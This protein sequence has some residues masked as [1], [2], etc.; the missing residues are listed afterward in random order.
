GVG[1]RQPDRSTVPVG[2]PLPDTT[3]HLLDEERRPVAP[4][5]RGEVW[6]GGGGVARGYAGRPELTGERFVPDPFGPPGGRLYR[7]GDLGRQGPG[8]ALELLGRADHQVKIRGHR[9]EPGEIE[10]WLAE[11]E[12][13][14]EAVVLP[15]PDGGQLRL[16]AYVRPRRGFVC[17]EARLREHAALRLPRPMLPAAYVTVDTWPRT[18]NGKI[19]R[20]ALP[21][22]V[23]PAP[24]PTA[25]GTHGPDGPDEPDGGGD[26]APAN[27]TVR[28]LAG[29][30]QDVLGTAAPP[31]PEAGFFALGGTS[32]D[33][34]RVVK[35][36]RV[37]FGVR[38][39]AVRMMRAESLAGQAAL[40]RAAVTAATG[41]PAPGPGREPV[42]G[43]GPAPEPGSVSEPDSASE[44]G[45]APELG[46]ESDRPLPAQKPGPRPGPGPEPVPQP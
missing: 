11:E 38:V 36:V 3:V 42:P 16:V 35:S 4:G 39:N 29:I 44:P 41:E 45:P 19:D 23:T 20:R 43:P 33:I 37:R 9:V 5:E 13:V 22:P 1:Q 24:P 28:V 17:A 15:R 21:E 46:S 34:T 40:V 6:I 8:G 14:A 27:G 18:P 25:G 10:S 26:A 12:S 30:W 7:T 2:L 32:L 31:G